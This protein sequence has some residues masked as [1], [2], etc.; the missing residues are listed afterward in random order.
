MNTP[1][2]EILQ[3][4]NNFPKIIIGQMEAARILN[5]SRNNFWKVWVETKILQPIYPGNKAH[6]KFYIFDVINAPEIL[7]KA[8]KT[9]DVIRG[10]W[11]ETNV[12]DIINQCYKET[13][14]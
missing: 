4:L 1:S 13:G 5:T 3:L 7:K 2:A 11:R 12:D 10:E 14:T 6:A 8:Q 9:N